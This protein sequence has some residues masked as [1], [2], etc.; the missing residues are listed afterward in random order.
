MLSQLSQLLTWRDQ[1]KDTVYVYPS[2]CCQCC[3]RLLA[4]T[5]VSV[6][7][8]WPQEVTEREVGNKVR[9]GRRCGR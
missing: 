1:G 6:E 2:S 5:E 3:G 8:V 7:E 4:G 9:W